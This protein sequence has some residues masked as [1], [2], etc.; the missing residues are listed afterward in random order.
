MFPVENELAQPAVDIAVHTTAA[1]I[2][3]DL[4]KPGSCRSCENY[5]DGDES[6]CVH[7]GF[8]LKG[9]EEEQ[10]QFMHNKTY[11]E[12]DLQTMYRKIKS[13]ATTLY[14]LAVLSAIAGAVLY[15]TQSEED[16][17]A[18]ILVVYIILSAIYA[19]LAVWTKQQPLTAIISGLVLFVI[20]QLLSMVEEPGSI[21]KGIIFKI[22]IVGYLVKGIRS[23]T[24]A[25][26]IKKQWSLQ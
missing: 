5:I 13:A 21:V 6:Y 1:A 26:R 22:I 7:C 3:D 9:S 14:V 8:P 19:A 18:A 11:M 24:E 17:P 12:M 23:A 2:D 16:N 4:S 20:V 15:G 25:N 10:T